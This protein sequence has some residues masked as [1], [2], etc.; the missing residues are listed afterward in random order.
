MG[1]FDTNRIHQKAVGN[2]ENAR[3]VFDKI[4]AGRETSVVQS[5]GDLRSGSNTDVWNDRYR[6]FPGGLSDTK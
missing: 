3:I 5:R 4:A 2:F 6:M 1:I